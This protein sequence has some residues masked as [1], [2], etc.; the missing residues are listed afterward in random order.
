M[1]RRNYAG[2]K[3]VM[4]FI[5][6]QYLRKGLK[7]LVGTDRIN[8]DN[9]A[10]ELLTFAGNPNLLPE[11]IRVYYYDAIPKKEDAES[12]KYEEQINYLK[13]VLSNAD[14]DIKLGRLKKLDKG[15][16]RQKGVDVQISIDMISKAYQNHYDTAVLVAGDDDF[17]DVVKAV[18]DTGKRV[19][20]AFFDKS[21]SD[22]LANSFD[23]VAVLEEDLALENLKDSEE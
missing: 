13:K 3:K 7:K 17:L 8:Y 16:F 12:I 22:S 10:D 11:L 14:Y 18:K 1:V 2:T 6:G 23:V 5:D 15:G 9:F 21:V 19:I 4:I 20:G